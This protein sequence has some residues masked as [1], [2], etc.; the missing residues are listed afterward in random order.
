M[1]RSRLLRELSSTEYTYWMAYFQANP[2]SWE[3]EGLHTAQI[4]QQQYNMNRAK[5]SS[6]AKLDDYILKFREPQAKEIGTDELMAKLSVLHM[7]YDADAQ[8]K[9]QTR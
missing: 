8:A 2:W 6:P 4:L 9:Q 5:G 7:T 3:L 1:T